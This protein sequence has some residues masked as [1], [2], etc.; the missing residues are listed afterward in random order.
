MS[1]AEN[2]AH[3]TDHDS[4]QVTLSPD[5]LDVELHRRQTKGSDFGHESVNP[6]SEA[7][8]YDGP[9][10]RLAQKSFSTWPVAIWFIMSSEFCERFSFYGLKAILPEFLKNYLH[11]HEDTAT[12]IIHLFIFGAYLLAIF[13]GIVSDMLLGKFKTI[14]LMSIVYI[15]GCGVLAA[16]GIPGLFKLGRQLCFVALFLIALGTGGIKPNISSFVGDQFDAR[17][18]EALASVFSVFYF[19]INAGSLCST[20]LTPIISTRVSYAWAFGIPAILLFV[21]TVLFALGSRGYTKYHIS[22]GPSVFTVFYRVIVTAWR[23]RRRITSG[24]TLGGFEATSPTPGGLS[25]VNMHQTPFLNYAKPIMGDQVVEDVR[26]VLRIL[27]VFVPL[28]IFWSLYDQ[29]ASKW[30]FMAQDMNTTIGKLTLSASHVQ[31]LNP[32]LTLSMIPVFDRLI[33]PFFKNRGITLHPLRHKMV[34][35]MLLTA[36]SFVVSGGLQYW[37]DAVAPKKLHVILMAPQ[38]W[39][40]SCAEVLVSIT[41]LEFAYSQAPKWLKSIIMS[42]WLFTTAVGNGLVALLALIKI[43]HRGLEFFLYAALMIL[44]TM[45]FYLLVRGYQMVTPNT[46]NEEERISQPLLA[47]DTT[48]NHSKP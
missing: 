40:L 38:F 1:D 24:R 27:L 25:P 3:F 4:Q 44:F 42:G 20:I 36:L 29:H 22:K 46:V 18:V 34:A 13:G 19:L 11:I 48:V 30:V 7:L 47:E 35:G 5:D 8:S 43:G 9:A 31:V 14:I 23:E 45:I 10:P 26:I 6:A 28:P 39:I 41:G 2:G 12:L 33:Y 15:I 32:L 37:M 17:S 21:A 16:A